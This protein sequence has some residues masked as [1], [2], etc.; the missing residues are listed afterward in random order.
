MDQGT[1]AEGNPGTARSDQRTVPKIAGPLSQ[2]NALD[3]AQFVS[4]RE[5][6]TIRPNLEPSTMQ[7]STPIVSTCPMHPEVRQDRPGRCPKSQMHLGPEG[8]VSHGHPHDHSSH[9]MHPA[10]PVPANAPVTTPPEPGGTVY[11]CPM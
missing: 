8:E 2:A 3:T 4:Q 9:S 11:T 1:V 6:F 10:V 7:A 5:A